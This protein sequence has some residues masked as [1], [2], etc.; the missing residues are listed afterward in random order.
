MSIRSTIKK[1]KGNQC[2]Q[3]RI[4]ISQ[5]EPQSFKAMMGLEIYLKETDVDPKLRQLIKIRASILN[6][7]TYCIQ[8]H[9]EESKSLGESEQR[10][11]ALSAWK[12]S[13][14]FSKTERAILELTDEITLITLQGVSE[15]TYI[16]CLEQLGEQALAQ[17]I[18]QI[19]TINMWNRIAVATKMTH[20]AD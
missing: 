9:T 10:L 4:N 8:M 15:A 16:E 20:E 3:T 6:N 7:C 12:E 17:C 18:M 1:P 11:H 5:L 14:L 13:S 2:M 19:V